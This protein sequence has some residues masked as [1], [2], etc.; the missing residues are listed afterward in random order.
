MAIKLTPEQQLIINSNQHMVINAVAGS[1]KTTTLVEYARTRPA[2]S[3]ILYLAFN[4]S[5]KTEAK[6]KFSQ[7]GL[8]NVKVETAHSL[9]YQYV[10]AGRNLQ[11]QSNGYKTYDLAELLGIETGDKH[12][13]YM[14]AGHVSRYMAYWCNS[15][16]A[17]VQDIDY[18]ATVTD[19][20]A[21]TFVNNYYSQILK[22]TREALAKMNS[23]QIGITHD[24][25]LKKFQLECPQ[26]P[27]D[28]ILFDEGQ[29]AS[30]A[31]L[32]VFLKQAGIKIIVGDVHQQIYGWRYAVNSL[33]QV[34]FPAMVLSQSF[35]FNDEVALVAN[36]ILRWK[37]ELL[38][39]QK[40][41]KVVGFD[42]DTTVVESKATLGRS[43]LALMG[44]A[45]DN[46]Q[47]LTAEKVYFEGNIN[48]YT[49]ADEGASLYDILNLQNGRR[50][51]IRDKLIG[52][53]QSMKDLTDYIEKTDD[54][55]LRMLVDVVKKYGNDLPDLIKGLKAQHTEKKEDAD[56]VYST[57]HRCKG[58]EYGE[59]FMLDDFMTEEKLR[60][61]IAEMGGI[62]IKY[63]DKSRMG[64]EVNLVY[65]AATRAKAKLHLP[66]SLNPFKTVQIVATVE[67]QSPPARPAMPSRYTSSRATRDWEMET[68]YDA[69]VQG[70]STAKTS[71][72]KLDRPS[73]KQPNSGKPW[74]D[75]DDEE[76]ENMFAA[77]RNIKKLSEH[78]ERTQTAIRR[79]LVKLNLLDEDDEMD[80][81]F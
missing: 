61:N 64:E 75:E 22:F 4:A 8:P 35:R 36:N 63:A 39:W 59:V 2:N 3:R 44:R 58:M 49:F 12:V 66:L 18:A 65:V 78:F 6:L 27:Y 81:P 48:S 29:D 14:L 34:D 62:N 56:M 37:Y 60:K 76:L 73:T 54:N 32:D 80:A 19:A 45:I 72:V 70:K 52:S 69:Y 42:V 71:R 33:Q 9:A 31:M 55:S 21:H 10:V 68:M 23:G 7:A 15:A 43:N 24:F 26:L 25:Y 67:Y 13:D 11:L 46:W 77:N 47:N 30:A 1:G 20:K 17:K 74:S 57:V 38:G 51:G 16:V 41:V 50:A 40:P 28:Y 79:R 5:V 53:M